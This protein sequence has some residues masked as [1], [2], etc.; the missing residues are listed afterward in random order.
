MSELTQNDARR[1]RSSKPSTLPW[2]SAAA[3][4]LTAS[5]VIAPAAP[6]EDSLPTSSWSKCI[7]MRTPRAS[8]NASSVEAFISACN[9][10]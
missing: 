1:V 2:L 5:V 8:A 4:R 10:V 7:I 3:M 9:D 6:L